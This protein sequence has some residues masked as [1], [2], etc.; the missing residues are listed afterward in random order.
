MSHETLLVIAAV[1]VGVL[2]SARIV[3]LVVADEFP[4][5]EWV[6]TRWLVLT[7]EGSWSKLIT[8]PWCL[9][10]YV[11]AANM[12]AALLSDLHAA[13]W[14]FNGWMAA[15]YATSWVVFHDED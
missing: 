9:A 14:I 12:A 5:V 3:R 8:C 7:G 10:P 1:V 4:P 13:W 11:V 15:S 6:K 2:G